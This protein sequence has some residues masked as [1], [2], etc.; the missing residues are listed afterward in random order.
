MRTSLLEAAIG[1]LDFQAARYTVEGVVPPRVGNHHPTLVPMGT[2]ATADG[3][4]NIAAIDGRIWLELTRVLDLPELLEDPRF[5]T[6]DLRMD[7]RDEINALVAARLR[8]RTTADWIADLEAAGVPAGPV[9][10]VGEV[11]ADAQVQHLEMVQPV[12]HPEM[13][14]LR[15]IANA[16]TLAGLPRALR[17][18]APAAGEHTEEILGELGL[19]PG[20]IAALSRRRGVLMPEHLQVADDGAITWLTFDHVARR[21]ALT[22]AMCRSLLAELE[23]IERDPEVH[24]VVLRGAG[25]D[26]FMS[27]A[28]IS[29][30]DDPEAPK[31]ITAWY[32][33]LAAMTKPVIAIGPRVLP[34]RRAGHRAGGGP[35]DRRR[36]QPL[37]D[38]GRTARRRLSVRRR[39][40]ARGPRRPRGRRGHPLHRPAAV[41]RGGA[42]G[43]AGAGAAPARGARGPRRRARGDDRGQRPADDPRGEGG[44]PRP[45]P[46][47]GRATRGR[48]PGIGGPRR[49]PPRVLREAPARVPRA[50]ADSVARMDLQLTGRRAIVTGASRG[51]GLATARA[52]AAEGADVAIVARDQVALDKAAERLS[53]DSGRTIVPVAADTGDDD[54][55]TAMVAQVVERL[56]GVDVLVNCAARPNTGQ[57]TDDA[58]ELEINVKVRGYLRCIRAVAPHM[59]A[60]GWGSIVNVAGVAA[61]RTGSV[62]GTIRNVAVAALTKNLS[63]ELGPQGINVN[64][65]HPAL[66]ITEVMP[67]VV[68]KV[69]EAKGISIEDAAAELGKDVSI[70]RIMTADEVA[71]VICFLASP[72][73]VAI[74]GDPVLASGG[75]KGSVYY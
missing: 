8:T 70:G 19:S 25:D 23:R 36:G 52:L 75:S 24:V 31:A 6:V 74:N 5:A 37:R 73:A 45:R 49:G 12:E 28:D 65:V 18:A 17:T 3:H 43:R 72:R 58:L 40:A 60:G 1:L 10:D 30:Q 59:A 56:G 9:N 21:N 54:S 2:F 11:F 29:E 4:V 34:R 67:P 66:T 32:A 53:T 68:T 55:V 20:D 48:V 51:I 41:G 62:T 61:R 27:G 42:G 14:E 57:L 71:T 7:Q 38:P 26:A 44:D 15:L 39:A 16:A 64:V 22:I 46:R 47:R 50:V 35:A 63:D 69:A 13:G 33:A